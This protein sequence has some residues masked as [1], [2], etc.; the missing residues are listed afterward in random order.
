MGAEATAPAKVGTK[1]LFYV[2]KRVSR[3]AIGFENQT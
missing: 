2:W 1:E 3:D